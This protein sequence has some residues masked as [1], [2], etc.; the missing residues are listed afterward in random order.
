MNK[1]K[2]IIVIVILSRIYVRMKVNSQIK[3]TKII[4]LSDIWRINRNVYKR[5]KK[6]TDFINFYSNVN[7][8][9]NFSKKNKIKS[10]ITI[11]SFLFLIAL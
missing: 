6:G 10:Q 8:H 5:T 9:S 1:I 2:I 3:K 11:M 4:Y 7:L